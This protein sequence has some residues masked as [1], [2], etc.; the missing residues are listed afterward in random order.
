[1]LSAMIRPASI[2]IMPGIPK[3][4]EEHFGKPKSKYVG[5]KSSGGQ[6]P[7]NSLVVYFYLSTAY[8]TN[9]CKADMIF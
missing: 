1:M 7:I 9:T 3:A 2:V 4:M 6:R 5:Q 8:A